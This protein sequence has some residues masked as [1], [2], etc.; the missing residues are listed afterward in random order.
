MLAYQSLRQAQKQIIIIQRTD[1]P[2]HRSIE[3]TIEQK[4]ILI[5]ATD[6]PWFSHVLRM[7]KKDHRPSTL[8]ETMIITIQD[9]TRE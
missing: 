2:L 9:G 8:L 1:I 3:E 7:P 6:Q 5:G 4:K